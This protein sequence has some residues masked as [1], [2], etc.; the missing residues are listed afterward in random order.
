MTWTDQKE[1]EFTELIDTLWN[2]NCSLL[3]SMLISILELIDTLWNVNNSMIANLSNVAWELID[4][5]WNVNYKRSDLEY[6]T[7]W[8]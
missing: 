1:F 3:P 2:V 5:L 6:N 7:I 4:T 8:N